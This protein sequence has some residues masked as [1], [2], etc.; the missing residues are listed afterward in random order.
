MDLLGNF[1]NLY[2]VFSGRE[3]YLSPIFSILQKLYQKNKTQG[4]TVKC[5]ENGFLT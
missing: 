5:T 4:K 2:I 1:S 3:C